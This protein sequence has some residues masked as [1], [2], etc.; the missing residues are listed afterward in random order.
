[1]TLRERLDFQA[2]QVRHL[3]V[4][5]DGTR[6]AAAYGTGLVWLFNL[7]SGN[8]LDVNVTVF[9]VG[10]A[11][12]IMG[13]AWSPDGGHLA[14]GMSEYDHF[15]TLGVWNITVGKYPTPISYERSV[16]GLR[17]LAWGP[18]GLAVA[19]ATYPAVSNSG[20]V[21]MGV[22]RLFP[23]AP[24]TVAKREVSLFNTTLLGS[25]DWS[26]AGD[27]L[28]VGENGRLRIYDERLRQVTVYDRPVETQE[29]PRFPR[30]APGEPGLP[31]GLDF[32]G[33]EEGEIFGDAT[34]V[35]AAGPLLLGAA[36]LG[37]ALLARRR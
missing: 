12:P 36:L 16:E 19:Y 24:A 25:L 22:L 31:G 4:S 9:N 8:V 15:G 28:A 27:R 34:D 29:P 32:E 23:E 20:E 2:P 37:V 30:L 35:P 5:P 14:V 21:P 17:G 1:A 18:E 11:D 33:E 6:L 13:M 3:A 10:S 26:P 7:T